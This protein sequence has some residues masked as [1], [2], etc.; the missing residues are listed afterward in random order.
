MNFGNKFPPLLTC[1][2]I[3]IYTYIYIAANECMDVVF[4]HFESFY[5]GQVRAIIRAKVIVAFYLVVS[6]DLLHIQLSF[7]VFVPSY[8]AIL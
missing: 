4:G 6:S 8:Q 2:D 1:I 3:Y 7:C 5:V